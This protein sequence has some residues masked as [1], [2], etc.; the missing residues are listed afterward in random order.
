MTNLHVVY[1]VDDPGSADEQWSTY[2]FPH[3]IFVAG[4]TLDEVRAEF[5]DAATALPDFDSVAIREH[6]ERPLVRGAYIR[7][8]VDRR[9]LDR[10]ETADMM[11]RS[12][13]VLDQREDFLA[14]LPVAATG[15]AVMIACQRTDRLRWVF[16]QMSEHDTV[17]VCA[18]GPSTEAGEFIWWSFIA[19]LH[20]ER[21]GDKPLESLAS[22]GLTSD[23][24]VVE[25][26]RANK[27]ATGRALVAA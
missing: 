3:G 11:R 24:S 10:D 1:R 2:S 20:A 9:M 22:G 6:L 23:S 7:V 13:S 17:G 15:D 25:F 26:M 12:V 4:S 21:L 18:S 5:R 16:E 14:T 19:G 27:S 8:A